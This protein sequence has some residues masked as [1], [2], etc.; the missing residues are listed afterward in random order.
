MFTWI[1]LKLIFEAFK[2]L[3]LQGSGKWEHLPSKLKPL[4][5]NPSTTKKKKIILT[6]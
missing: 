2:N 5:T 4:N 3:C 6:K 1:F